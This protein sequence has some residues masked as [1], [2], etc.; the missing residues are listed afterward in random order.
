LDSRPLEITEE[1][2]NDGVDIQG[3]RWGIG[4]V[5]S[6]EDFREKRYNHSIFRLTSSVKDYGSLIVKPPP[7]PVSV[8]PVSFPL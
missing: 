5:P 6:K 2:C 4:D 8:N 7:P 1:E 3:L